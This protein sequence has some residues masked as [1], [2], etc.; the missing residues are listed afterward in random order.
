MQTNTLTT[1]QNLQVSTY[2]YL[3]QT[4][5]SAVTLTI[6]S[7]NPSVAIVSTSAGVAGGASI[8]FA[9]LTSTSAMTYYVQGLAVGTSNLTVSAPGY[10]SMSIALTVDPSGFIIYTPG[11]FT[12]TTF[13]TPTSVTLLP[14]ILNSGVLTVAGYASLNPGATASVPVTSGTPSVGTVTTPVNFSGGS[15]SATFSFQPVA[16]GSTLLSLGAV[17][18]FTTPSQ[19]STQ[20][21]NA[22][23]TAPPIGLQTTAITTGAL[24]QVSTYAYLSVAPPS[25]VSLTL[26]SADP[27][28]ATV[29]TSS[30]VVGTQAIIFSSVSS[31]SAITYYVQGQAAGS[32]TITLSAPGFQSAS[33]TVTVD[34]SGFVIYTP[35]NFSTTAGAASTSVT[36]LPAILNSGLLTVAGYGILNPGM[37]SVAVPVGSTSPQIG[38][39]TPSSLS[40]PAA[41][42]SGSLQFTPLQS[43]ST[44][45]V[46]VSQPSGFTTPSQ[47]NTQQIVVTVN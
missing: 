37:A 22:T 42:S 28:V 17:S 26:T 33:V 11:S 34:P 21:I 38:T 9:G 15:S 25:P 19:S 13:S 45:V 43:G 7:S 5:P 18:G 6:S 20:Q 41:S 24:L 8:G 3:S 44:D 16:S 36:I 12:T 10:S 30:G 1:G 29:S 31:A 39:V 46:I 2:A 47:P 40:F 32:T 35:S 23:V 14:A 27:T 4:P